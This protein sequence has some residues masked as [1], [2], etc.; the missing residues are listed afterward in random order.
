[1]SV[2][3]ERMLQDGL[4]H[5]VHIANAGLVLL[6]PYFPLLFDRLGLLTAG[7]DGQPHMGGPEA[8]SRAVHLLQYLVTGRL[9]TPEP[10]LALNKLLAGIPLSA[11][12]A[13]A[14]AVVETDLEI[15]GGLLAAVIAHWPQ[16]RD[17]SIDGLRIGWLQREGRIEP[18]EDFWRLT[19]QRRSYDVLLQT[20]PW[21]FTLIR[22]R[23]MPHLIDVTWDW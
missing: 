22:H 21:S 23:W 4:G 9:D 14:I 16:M 13:P 1:M 18:G 11:P 12:V 2:E 10:E 17:T 20:L 7:T 8:A 3:I 15:C 19:V 5:P 6:H